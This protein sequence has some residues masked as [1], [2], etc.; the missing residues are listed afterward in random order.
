MNGVNRIEAH[1]CYGY[2]YGWALHQSLVP[3]GAAVCSSAA[4]TW[5]HQ[6]LQRLHEHHSVPSF[7]AVHAWPGGVCDYDRSLKTG[8]SV[9]AEL[10]Q[11]L[12]SESAHKRDP[13]DLRNRWACSVSSYN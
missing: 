11:R 8:V 6:P 12:A 9:Q 7:L 3:S 4:N 1:V 10:N 2:A 13:L 5:D